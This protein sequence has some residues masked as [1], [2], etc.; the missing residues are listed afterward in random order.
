MRFVN[1]YAVGTY[2]MAAR[3]NRKEHLFFLSINWKHQHVFVAVADAVR[4]TQN[5]EK[6]DK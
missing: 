2:G 5:A 4:Q 6:N 3:L 1:A